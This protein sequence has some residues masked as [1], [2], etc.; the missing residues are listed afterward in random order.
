MNTNGL[1]RNSQYINEIGKYCDIL[2]FQETWVA[3][4]SESDY[5][6]SIPLEFQA[7]SMKRTRKEGK[8][9]EW[10]VPLRG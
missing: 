8:R 9:G 1:E 2:F 10:K 5:I 7:F 4:I 3:D 6:N